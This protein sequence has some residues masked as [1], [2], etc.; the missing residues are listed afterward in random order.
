[1]HEPKVLSDKKYVQN[2]QH[3]ISIDLKE[4]FPKISF[5]DEE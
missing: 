5:K 1:M 2:E 4:A 3:N